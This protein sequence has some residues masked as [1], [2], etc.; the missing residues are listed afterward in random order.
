MEGKL[1]SIEAK[2]DKIDDKLGKFLERLA[3]VEEKQKTDRGALSLGF[4]VFMAFLGWVVY[5]LKFTL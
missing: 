2:L 3:V 4:T 5:K 1:N